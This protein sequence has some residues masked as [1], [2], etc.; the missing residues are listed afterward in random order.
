M[1]SELLFGTGLLLVLAGFALAFFVTVAT[2]S[3]GQTRGGGVI[4]IGPIPI[5][6]GMDRRMVKILVAFAVVSLALVFGLTLLAWK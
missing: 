5:I 4:L 6:F 2:G 1:S 3:K